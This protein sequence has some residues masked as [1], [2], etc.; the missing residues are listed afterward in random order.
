MLGKKLRRRKLLVAIAS[1]AAFVTVGIAGLANNTQTVAAKTKTIYVQSTKQQNKYIK[2]ANRAGTHYFK[3][4]KVKMRAYTG[5]LYCDSDDDGVNVGAPIYTM[6]GKIDSGYEL[7][8][9]YTELFIGIKTINGQHFFIAK[10]SAGKY[11][12][13]AKDFYVPT[14]YRLKKG[15][16]IKQYQLVRS[17]DGFFTA[18]DFKNPKLE[19][20]GNYIWT[21][22]F[23][24]VLVVNAKTQDG[25]IYY[26]GEAY[27]PI[28]DTDGTSNGYFKESDIKNNLVKAK[29]T[30]GVGDTFNGNKI[31]HIAYKY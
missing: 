28:Y 16:H 4:Y 9:A 23:N 31:V 12:R 6:N 2:M 18:N 10:D 21:K 22:M 15:H 3:G 24:R 29:G 8:Q 11:L 17:D 19:L 1:I 5:T 14:S 13:L 26:K 7:R 27:R 20:E 25:R 30:F